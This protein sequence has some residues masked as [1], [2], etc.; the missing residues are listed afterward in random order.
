MLRPGETKNVAHIYVWQTKTNM[1]VRINREINNTH[2]YINRVCS[3]KYRLNECNEWK[4]QMV[5]A[6]I[7]HRWRVIST[8]MKQIIGQHA[9]HLYS[10]IPITRL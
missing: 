9:H 7:R 3:P 10:Q 1:C 8:I 5:R 2:I 4:W 6:R